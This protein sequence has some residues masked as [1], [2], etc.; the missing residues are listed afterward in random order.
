MRNELEYLAEI[1]A[2]VLGQHPNP[3]SFEQK[4][5]TDAGLRNDV[6]LIRD[7]LQAIE[8]QGIKTEIARAKTTYSLLRALRWLGMVLGV[9]LAVFAAALIY[10]QSSSVTGGS[11]KP[12]IRTDLPAQNEIGGTEWVQADSVLPTL[13]YTLHADQDEVVETPGGILISIPKGS[14]RQKNGAPLTGSYELEVKEALD[15]TTIMKAGLSTWS[16]GRLLETGG[17][18]YVNMRQNG[19]NLQIPTDAGIT[20]SVPKQENRSDMMLFDGVRTYNGEPHQFYTESNVTEELATDSV[21]YKIP[22]GYINWINP[23]KPISDLISIP[24]EQLNFYPPGFEAKLAETGY[25]DRGKVFKDSVYLSFKAMFEPVMDGYMK[26]DTLTE[27][28]SDSIFRTAN[29]TN[30]MTQ[31]MAT[32]PEIS[33]SQTA[34]IALAFQYRTGLWGGIDPGLV[35]AFWNKEFDRSILATKE[36]ETRMRYIHGTCDERILK[37][38]TQNINQPLYYCD[39]LAAGLSAR[40]QS[41]QTRFMQ[42]YYQKHGTPKNSKA[43]T[44]ALLSIFAQKQRELDAAYNRTT[45]TWYR[46]QAQADQ[47][48][49]ENR[50]NQW[51]R[52][53]NREQSNFSKEFENNLCEAKKQLGKS[54]NE[55]P[56]FSRNV[57]DNFNTFNLQSTGWKNVDAYVNEATLSRTSMEYTDPETGKKA[58]LTYTPLTV[59]V[60]NATGYDIREAYLIPSGK[61]SFMRMRKNGDT[62]TE[63]LNAL[64]QYHLVA[65]GYKGDE[66][67]LYSQENITA[68]SG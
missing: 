50:L 21:S 44:Q 34:E 48:A 49:L 16:D 36:F 32:S 4:L 19:E 7:L 37:C 25:P 38:Y 35:L 43:F 39:S 8:I 55:Q 59:T 1:E 33:F 60:N 51:V 5:H 61:L 54:C 57:R 45:G 18:F 31:V 9:C 27:G 40:D 29:V 12:Y 30:V 10:I 53:G 15:A 67:F 41:R 42:F 28:I 11:G 58:T 63:S 6:N 47:K 13:V 17:M 52:D 46:E 65:V 56:V 24:M 68:G 3:R 23:R 64:Y 2:Y 20:V 66:I 14:L 22:N 26:A 62:F